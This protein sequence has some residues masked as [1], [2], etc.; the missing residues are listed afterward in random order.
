VLT[1]VES[2][3]PFQANLFYRSPSSLYKNLSSFDGGYMIYYSYMRDKS[4]TV[5]NC[6]PLN[7]KALIDLFERD[8]ELK[9]YATPER[10][11]LITRYFKAVYQ[12]QLTFEPVQPQPNF[13]LNGIVYSVKVERLQA[14]L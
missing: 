6:S 11:K 1:F 5:L 12:T 8:K 10:L 3:I 2:D 14:T 9:F 7:F 4:E 13:I